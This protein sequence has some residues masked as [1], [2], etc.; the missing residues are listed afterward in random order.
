MSRMSCAGSKASD[1]R[2]IRFERRET[3]EIVCRCEEVDVRQRRLHAPRLRRIVAP[4]NQRIE[5]DDF[6]AA[7]A[8]PPH[9]FAEA[10]RFAGVVAVGDDHDSGARIDDAPRVPT[11][12][13]SEAF[14]DARAAADALSHQRQFVD[15]AGYVAIAQRRRDVR[16]PGVKDEGFG[17]AEA[18]DDAMQEADKKRR[19]EAHR[20]RSVEQ[21]DEPQRFDLAAT[22]GQ[23]D[24]SAAVGDVAMDSTAQIEAA[25]AAGNLLAANKPRSHGAG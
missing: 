15:G 4:A 9:F 11:V 8:E 3:F 22:P 23:L 16:E 13:R 10:L 5:P 17:F 6:A 2:E 1:P 19:V 18:V 21:D 12:E 20:T 7:P 24:Q 14:A 25:A